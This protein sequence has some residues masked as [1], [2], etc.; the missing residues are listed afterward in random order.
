M[1]TSLEE[2]DCVNSI[3]TSRQTKL[4]LL[5]QKY[6]SVMH[7]DLASIKNVKA[8]LNLKTGA[9]PVFAKSRPVPFKILPLIEKKS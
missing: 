9:K 8:R 5:L 4:D 1:K 2:I 6:E 3:E 7:E